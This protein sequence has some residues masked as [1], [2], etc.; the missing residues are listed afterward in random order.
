MKTPSAK[1][2]KLPGRFAEI[3]VWFRSKEYTEYRALLQPFNLHTP[4]TLNAP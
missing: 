1:N 4:R 3:P 2:L